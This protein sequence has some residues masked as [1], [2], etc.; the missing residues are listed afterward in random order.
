MTDQDAALEQLNEFRR[1][2]IGRVL[3]RARWTF[4][5]QFTERIQARGF[6]DFRPADV[7]LISRLPVEGA[8]VTDLAR[9]ASISKQAIGKLVTGLESRGYVERTPDPDD[10]RAHRIRLTKRGRKFLEAAREVVAEIEE[11]WAE[12]LG[13][14]GLTRLRNALATVSDALGE[15]EFF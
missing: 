8:R 14:S 7:D 15:A 1:T 13:A 11:T 9:R 6:D 2:H 4:E 12:V 10:G 5:A 3:A